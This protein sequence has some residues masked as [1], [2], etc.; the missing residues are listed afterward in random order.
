MDLIDFRLLVGILDSGSVTRG[1]ERAF[2]S[3]PAASNRVK[4]LEAEL[5]VILFTRGSRGM[6]PTPA[7]QAFGRHARAILKQLESLRQEVGEFAT[8]GKGCVRVHGSTSFV[9]SFLPDILGDYLAGHP[10][11]SVDTRERINVDVVRDLLAGDADIGLVC[12]P[13]YRDNLQSHFLFDDPMVLAVSAGH[14][15]SGRKQMRFEETLE[16]P[17]VGLHEGSTLARFV[18]SHAKLAGRA[19]VTR[20]SVANY[21]IMC[22]M[23]EAG[24]GVGLMPRSTL[25]RYGCVERLCEIGLKDE[26]AA[27]TRELLVC[28]DSDLP[29]H[30]GSLLRDISR[31]AINWAPTAL[32]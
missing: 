26:W 18:K 16:A 11:V 5:N 32:A 9:S 28:A 2:L 25:R 20:V 7:G 12:G 27:R 24:L 13:V 10:E 31:K 17:H 19:Q 30:V 22:R 6:T 8:G 21:E 4:H 29:D 23:I 1:A 15:W 14:A 3:L